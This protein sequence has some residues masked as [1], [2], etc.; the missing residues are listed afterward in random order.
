MQLEVAFCLFPVSI[1]HL[2]FWIEDNALLEW[3]VRCFFVFKL[4]N[5]RLAC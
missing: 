4:F 5:L 3:L 1:S 2:V